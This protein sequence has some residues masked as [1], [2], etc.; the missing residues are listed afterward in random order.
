MIVVPDV[1]KPVKVL[2]GELGEVTTPPPERILHV[3]IPIDGVF[4]ANV[5]L[6]VLT[7]IVCD[8]PAMLIGGTLL[9]IILTVEVEGGHVPLE[10]LHCKIVVPGIDKPVIVLLGEFGEVIVPPPE[11]I[12]QVPNPTA[13][14]LPA[15]TVLPVVTQIVCVTPAFAVVGI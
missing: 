5:T 4:A 8:V 9:I 1:D 11:I 6:P 3:P 7:Q 10:I 13:G 15:S 12:L 2:L 14:I